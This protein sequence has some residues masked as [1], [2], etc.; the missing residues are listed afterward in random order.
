M[1][2]KTPEKET[3]ECPKTELTGEMFCYKSKKLSRR[4]KEEW[5]HKIVDDPKRSACH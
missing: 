4:A 2:A 1:S 5:I 3:D